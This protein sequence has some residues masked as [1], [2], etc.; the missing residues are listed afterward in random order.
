MRFLVDENLPPR[1]VVWLQVRGHDAVH[2]S[3]LPSLSSDKDIA[4]YAL[5]EARVILTKDGDFDPPR[6]GERVLELAIGNCSNPKLFAWLEPR[7]ETALARLGRGE[8]HVL[9]D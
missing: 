8:A 9:V 4:Q 7:L 2:V 1:L 5:R 3:T 6:F